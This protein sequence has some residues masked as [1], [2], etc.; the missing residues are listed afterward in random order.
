MS[1]SQ[2]EHG[3]L[4]VGG[5]PRIDFLPTETKM[6]KAN[7]RSRRS[8]VALVAMVVIVCV[9]G[10]LTVNG[11]AVTS[12]AALEDE[13][14]KTQA[15][16]DQQ[17]SFSELRGLQTA[18]A[19]IK[20]ARVVVSATQILWDDQ[21]DELISHLPLGSGIL[22]ILVES[23]SSSDSQP[24]PTGIFEKPRVAEVSLTFEVPDVATADA[25]MVALSKQEAI[26]D[27]TIASIAYDEGRNW[28]VVTVTL[29]I[30]SDAFQKRYPPDKPDGVASDEDEE[31]TPTP[32][33][34]PTDTAT[35]T[36]TA[37]P[38]TEG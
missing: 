8:L 17:K 18:L 38:G 37:T 20:S 33:P 15:L 12:Q 7:R 16:L 19:T 3:P 36:P 25:I 11:L 13:R 24:Q 32:T 31:P 30:T 5:E 6:R 34:T 35:P 21:M 1:G 29:H 22:E 10:V 23:M 4:V 2:R 14:A 28:Y 26:A 27:A 9:L